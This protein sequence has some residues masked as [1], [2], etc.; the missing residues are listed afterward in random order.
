MLTAPSPVNG[1]TTTA[2]LSAVTLQWQA[3]TGQYM[4]GYNV[5]SSTA[6]SG[7]FT[8]LNTAGLLSV[9]STGYKDATA[10]AGVTTYYQ[11]VAVNVF[12]N[13][14]QPAN[15]SGARLLAPPT[16]TGLVA[17]APITGGVTLTWNAATGNL[18]GYNVYRSAS[19][20]GAYVLLNTAGA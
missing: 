16:P 9:G 4:A 5:Y 12:G 10:P 7:P 18:V 6:P 1:L 14:A 11:V 17:A 8:L 3:E 19:L 15:A 13:T 20:N 2:S